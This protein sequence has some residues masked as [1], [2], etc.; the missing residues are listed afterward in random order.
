MHLAVYRGRADVR[1]VVHA[2]PP[3]ATAFAICRRPLKTP[4]LAELVL[5]LG[6]VPVT[7]EFAMLS[8][9][10]VPDSIRPYLPDHNAVLLAN[11]G[12]L[13]WGGDLWQAFD[14]METVE[15]TAKTLLNVQ[16]LGGGVPLR[17]DQVQTLIGMR[18]MYRGLSEKTK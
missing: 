8:T 16:A 5:G 6:E 9:Q 10:E 1:A 15:H 7:A 12:A 4:Y 18:D 3:A 2:H 11:H 17:D 13:A 14:R